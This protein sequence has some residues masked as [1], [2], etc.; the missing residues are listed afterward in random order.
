ML[1]YL[2]TIDLYFPLFMTARLLQMILMMHNWAF[3]RKI[4]T[5]TLIRK[6]KKLSLVVKH[7]NTSS[8]LRV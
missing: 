1:T 3:Q 2:Q 7:K 5:Q 6:L 8:S 4:L